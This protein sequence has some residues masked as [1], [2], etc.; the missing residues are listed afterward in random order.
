MKKLILFILIFNTSR[1]FCQDINGV[2]FEKNT[3]L[4]TPSVLYIDD[5]KGLQDTSSV[6]NQHSFSITVF[7]MYQIGKTQYIKA[8]IGGMISKDEYTFKTFSKPVEKQVGALG[9]NILLEKRILKRFIGLEIGV[10]GDYFFTGKNFSDSDYPSKKTTNIIPVAIGGVNFVIGNVFFSCRYNYDLSDIKEQYMNTQ[11]SQQ[12]FVY[13][14]QRQ[15]LALG[16][17]M[18]FK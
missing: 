13:K 7:T 17:G 12:R 11:N 16:I 2:R 14:N 4:N 15:N 3:W 9:I 10:G 5:Q 1:V 8:E 18:Y 6:S